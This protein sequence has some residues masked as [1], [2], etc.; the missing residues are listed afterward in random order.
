MQLVD[1]ESWKTILARSEKNSSSIG[2]NGSICLL[3]NSVEKRHLDIQGNIHAFGI[4]LLEIISGRPSFCKDRGCLIDWVSN[5]SE[6]TIF[7]EISCCSTLIDK[8]A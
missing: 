5:P 2:N 1:F 6:S 4:L 8:H 3:P 7:N